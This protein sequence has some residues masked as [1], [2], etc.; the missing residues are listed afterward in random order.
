ML[1]DKWNRMLLEHKLDAIREHIRNRLSVAS[2]ETQAELNYILD[3]IRRR[4]QMDAD[5]KLS[6]PLTSVTTDEM[7]Q[8]FKNKG[9]EQ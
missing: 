3:L 9:E 2:G 7:I 1:T 8:C 4:E 5:W 6:E